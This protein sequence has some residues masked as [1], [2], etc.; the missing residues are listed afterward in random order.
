MGFV[1]IAGPR[2]V[3]EKSQ[4]GF[5]GQLITRCAPEVTGQEGWGD[6]PGRVR[7][8]PHAGRTD[9]QTRAGV[10]GCISSSLL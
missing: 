4:G 2:E 10:G 6:W 3:W 9:R 8:R 7:V 5:L 1:Q